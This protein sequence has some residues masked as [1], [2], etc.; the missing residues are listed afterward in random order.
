MRSPFTEQ[1]KGLIQ[2]LATRFPWRSRRS[3]RGDAIH[4]YSAMIG[5]VI[6]ARAAND[7]SFSREI[8][9]EARKRIV[10]ADVALRGDSTM[11]VSAQ[12]HADDDMFIFCIARFL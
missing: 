12:R 8:I 4:L 11:I 5:A 1:L 6:L 9:A 2:K 3:A 10:E 7:E